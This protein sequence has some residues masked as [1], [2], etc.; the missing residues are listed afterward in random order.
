[1]KELLKSVLICQSYRKNKS[2]TFF[3]AHGVDTRWRDGGRRSRIVKYTL[4]LTPS[5]T[6]ILGARGAIPNL[7]KKGESIFHP[8]KRC[9]KA[10]KYTN[11]RAKILFFPRGH[12]PR[13]T[14]G[15]AH[16]PH[17]PS[18]SAPHQVT[19]V[20]AARPPTQESW[21]FLWFL[22]F[23]ELQQSLSISCVN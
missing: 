11:F 6:S 20:H 4:H 7:K 12:S 16:P 9:Q 3:M 13:P 14:L 19:I 21:I 5:K 22:C 8:P 18:P 2:G 10:P 23:Y 1:V 17:I 15:M